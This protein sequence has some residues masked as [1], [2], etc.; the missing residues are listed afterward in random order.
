MPMFIEV[1]EYQE[2][3]K[4]DNL[5]RLIMRAIGIDISKTIGS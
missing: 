3:Y 2:Q 4:Q 1:P 5:R